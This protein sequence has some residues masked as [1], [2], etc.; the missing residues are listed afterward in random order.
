MDPIVIVLILIIIVLVYFL[1]YSYNKSIQN[2]DK[3]FNLNNENSTISSTDLANPKSSKFSY[4][5][6]IYVNTWNTNFRKDIIIAKST[7]SS[8]VSLNLGT[9]SP[10]LVAQ[11]YNN[12]PFTLTNNFPIQKWVHI[13]ITVDSNVVDCYLDGKM[14]VSKQLTNIINIPSS[15]AINF[16][17]FDAYLTGFEYRSEPMNP[18]QVW[19]KYMSG[20]GYDGGKYGVN[21]AITKDDK[22]VSQL[23]Y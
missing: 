17:R 15:Y 20:N 22:V 19:S 18:Q 4:T 9:T 7:D 6:W 13:V 8:I 12:N 11:I 1:Y 3:L 2:K 14:V 5:I 21:L 10:T 23:T 16:G